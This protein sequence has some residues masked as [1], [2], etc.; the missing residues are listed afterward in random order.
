M[1]FILNGLPNYGKLDN[2]VN[3]GDGYIKQ[4]KLYELKHSKEPLNYR[5]GPNYVQ[6]I[7]HHMMSLTEYQNSIRI[8]NPIRRKKQRELNK[9]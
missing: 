7:E 9:W 1:S 8:L 6:K 4:P 3:N 2:I 5:D